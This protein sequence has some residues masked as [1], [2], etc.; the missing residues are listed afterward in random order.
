M[1]ETEARACIDGNLAPGFVSERLCADNGLFSWLF[2]PDAP[3]DREWGRQLLIR[4]LEERSVADRLARLVREAGSNTLADLPGLLTRLQARQQQIAGLLDSP[5]RSA[6]PEGYTPPPLKQSTTGVA[7]LDDCMDGGDAPGEVYGVLGPF[8]AG[9][10]LFA[11]HAACAKARHLRFRADQGGELRHVYLFHY[12]AGFAEI[13]RRVWSHAAKVHAQT[14]KDLRWE[15]LSTRGHLNPYEMEEF[16]DEIAHA[17]LA[18]VD[19]ERERLEQALPEIRRNLW[20]CDFSGPPEAP[21][22]GSGYVDEIAAALERERQA[23]RLPGAVFIDYAG[24]CCDRH[25]EAKDLQND[26][27][28]HLLKAFG[29]RCLRQIAAPFGCCVWVLHQL[30]GEANKKGFAASQSHADA[31]ECKSFAENLWFCFELG[32]RDPASGVLKLHCTKS[33]R[34]P[35]PAVP[36]LLKMV[37]RYQ[38]LEAAA[39][40]AVDPSTGT[41]VLASHYYTV[42]SPAAVPAEE[43]DPDAVA[44]SPYV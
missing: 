9:K 36:P 31:A 14:L 25:V 17:G 37:G 12:E 13:V 40:W 32:A 27:K 42:H 20:L 38:R 23:G 34:A 18:N 1:V 8:A 30:S 19:G 5:V 43:A 24:L 6:A 33:R 3:L 44:L 4:F 7:W 35:A 28:R 10:T 41:P 2:S 39:G 26:D 21:A 15:E 22:R 16:A 11:V 29:H